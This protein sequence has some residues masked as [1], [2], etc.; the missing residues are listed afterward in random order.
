MYLLVQ[1]NGAKYWRL[2]YRN[3]KKEKLLALGVYP[4]ISLA[5]ARAARDAAK[6]L[7]RLDRD[8][9]TVKRVHKK[10]LLDEQ[11]HTFEKISAEWF[12]NKI[13]DKSK[14]YSD[15]TRRILDKDLL[16]ALGRAPIQDISTQQL[17]AVLRIIERRTVDIAHRAR[18]VASQI[19]R[20]AIASDIAERDIAADLAGALKNRD[21]K[22]AATL[23]DLGEIG[24]LLRSIDAYGGSMV[25]KTALQLSPLLFVGPEELRTMEGSEINRTVIHRG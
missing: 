24:L 10:M 17:L 23:L 21:V 7:L 6:K 12:E 15:R 16:P 9:S 13:S 25:V 20:Y 3:G 11:E 5:A 18:Q 4:E 2:K 8:P 19:F 1:P 14:S 22:H